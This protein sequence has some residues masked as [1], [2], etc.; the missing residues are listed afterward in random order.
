MVAQDDITAINNDLEKVKEALEKLLNQQSFV[1]GPINIRNQAELRYVKSLGE[2]TNIRGDV[3]VDISTETM[4]DSIA[5]VNAIISKINTIIG[6][7][8]ST[9]GHVSD[10]L[11]LSALSFVDGNL[12]VKVKANSIDGLT[13]VS[14]DLHLDYKADYVFPNLASTGSITVKDYEEVTKVDFPNLLP[15]DNG[16]TFQT[17]NVASIVSLSKATH[18]DL[19]GVQVR[20]LTAPKALIV[21]LGF[22]G[23]LAGTTT[24]TAAEA[25][26]ITLAATKIG[27]FPLTITGKD[28][29]TVDLSGLKEVGAGLTVSGEI[30]DVTALTTVTGTLIIADAKTLTLPNLEKADAIGATAATTFSAEKL[31]V[32]GNVSLTAAK[33]ITLAS[34]NQNFLKIVDVVETITLTELKS[35]FVADGFEA[36]ETLNVTGKVPAE[37]DVTEGSVAYGLSSNDANSLKTVSIDGALGYIS[38]VEND[39]LE[40]ITKAGHIISCSIEENDNLKTVKFGHSFLKGELANIIRVLGN[41]ELTEVDLTAVQK[42][43]TLTITDNDELASIKVGSPDVLAEPSTTITFLVNSNKLPGKYTDGKA[44]TETTK[45]SAPVIVQADLY[46]IKLVLD[47]YNNQESRAASATFDLSFDKTLDDDGEETSV[48]L[49]GKLNAD[50]AAQ[51][52][53]DADVSTVADNDTNNASTGSVSG[54]DIQREL[55]LLKKE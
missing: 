20:S 4:H 40:S 18:V 26:N 52:G 42:I 11:D 44:G 43:K 9:T 10:V 6:G 47:A 31:V 46:A 17:G 39:E 2:I 35:T 22:N 13:A 16:G 14:G 5:V 54:I 25:T 48:S 41:D 15:N 27:A 34:T 51:V 49:N 50:A 28:D 3:T 30:V 33:E 7:N 19:G 24:I 53:L 21:K 8:L 29:G 38:F 36:L 32:S 12:T 1:Q 37:K 45:Y 23:T 55:V